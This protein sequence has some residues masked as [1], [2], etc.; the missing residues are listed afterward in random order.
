MFTDEIRPCNYKYQT[1]KQR[2]PSIRNQNQCYQLTY[3]YLHTMSPNTTQPHPFRLAS[4]YP[5][6]LLT[7]ALLGPFPQHIQALQNSTPPTPPSRRSF[8]TNL[9]TTGAFGIAALTFPT[10]RACA[11]PPPSKTAGRPAYRGGNKSITD[12]HNGTDLNGREAGVASGLL[13]KMGIDNT[14]PLKDGGLKRG[15]VTAGRGR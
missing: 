2:T 15:V 4:L 5:L 14:D 7:T 10:D 12:T 13:G 3:Y 6:L 8:V 11:A 9:A 1:T